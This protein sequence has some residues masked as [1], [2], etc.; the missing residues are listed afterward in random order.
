MNDYFRGNCDSS[1]DNVILETVSLEK[2]CQVIVCNN[3]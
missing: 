1:Y 2:I 3:C